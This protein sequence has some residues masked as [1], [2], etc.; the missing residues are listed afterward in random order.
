[1]V[2]IS[3]AK[4]WNFKEF[5]YICDNEDDPSKVTKLKC[6]VCSE[7]YG[8]KSNELEKLKGMVKGL[9]KRWV[10]G[11]EVVKKSNAADHLKSNIH[12]TAVKRLKEKKNAT[13][14][15]QQT[16]TTEGQQ[17]AA[18]TSQEKTILEY[19]RE[20]SKPDRAKL[21]K[22]FQLVHFLTVNNKSLNFYQK[23]VR[24]QKDIYKVDVG[25]GYL[26]N[27]A[28]QEILLFLSRSIIKENI[29][30]PL[31]SGKRLYFSLLTD[32]SSSAKTMDEKEVYV[33]KTCDQ[34]KPRFDVLAL[35][36]PDDA[37]ANGLKS[38]LDDAVEKAKLTIGRK[39]HEIGLGS[40][41]TN[42]NKVLY[43]L[44]KEEIGEHL[45]Q[46]L[47]LSHKL[48]LAIHDAFKPS[49][50]NEDAE[51]QLVLVYYLFK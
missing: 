45:I 3:V 32:G 34:G 49:K 43:R 12:S 26:N 19:V 24:F 48:E 35:Q 20:L 9:V 22:K 33:I 13:I 36:Q 50:I 4:K 17:I 37:D 14:E 28:A 38:S 7:F 46:V 42:T 21:T 30:E 29:T 18:S 41:R 11:S 47:C 16:A 39:A 25:T 44:E 1:M 2:R 10:S 27:K 51:E 31:N 15:G 23:L 40:D 5:K 6:I 8:E